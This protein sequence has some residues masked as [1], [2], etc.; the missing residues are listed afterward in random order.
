ML[1]AALA[2]LVC[3]WLAVWKEKNEHKATRA[4]PNWYRNKETNP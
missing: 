1:S 4:N 2:M 3:G